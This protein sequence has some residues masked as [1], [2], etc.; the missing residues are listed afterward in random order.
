MNTL[1]E[2]SEVEILATV[3]VDVIKNFQEL[4]PGRFLEL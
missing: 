3:A 1:C 4:I 2:N